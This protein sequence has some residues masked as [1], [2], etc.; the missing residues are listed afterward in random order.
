MITTV[1]IS[2]S[3]TQKL[4]VAGMLALL[5]APGTAAA[6]SAF[7]GIVVFGTSLS[8]SGNAFALNGAAGTPHD[9]MMNPLLIPSAPYAKGG[10]HFSNG[11]T[12]IEQYA[13]I[14]G[15]AGSVRPALASSGS[16]TNFAVGAARAYNDGINFNL[17]RQVDTFLERSGGIAAPD[18]LYVIEMGSNDVRDAFQLYATGGNGGPI[19][20]QALGS[21]AANIQRLY[22]AGARSF[23][24]WT[25][26]NVALTPAIR[27]LPPAAQGLMSALTQA[28]NANL[29]GVLGQLSSGLPGVSFTRLD[30]YQLLGVIV[31]D[32]ATY[33]LTSVTTACLTPNEAPFSCDQPDEYLF[34]DGIHPT[35]AAHALLAH[36]A[37]SVLP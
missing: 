35:R 25:V 22:L 34:W 4:I 1:R 32:P 31:A 11:A 12:W 27:S 20:A 30:A 9:F 36:L 37:A 23:L 17:T 10:H 21:I 5:A 19:V 13:R 3:F 29:A 2:Q 6:Q 16:A 24:V 28:F 15:L 14:V 7:S 26:P 18:A 33:H 8:D